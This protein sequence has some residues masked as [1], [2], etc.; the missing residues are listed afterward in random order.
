MHTTGGVPSLVKGLPDS[1]PLHE[2]FVN[3]EWCGGL[4]S[5]LYLIEYDWIAYLQVL[6]QRLTSVT[7]SLDTLNLTVTLSVII[8]RRSRVVS[9][10]TDV[11]SRLSPR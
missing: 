9:F 8:R 10:F 4:V 7:Y 2:S 1:M 6:H 11:S 5:S 3:S